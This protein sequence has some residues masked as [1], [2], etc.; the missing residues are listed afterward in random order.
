M[1]Q[2]PTPTACRNC[3]EPRSE[4]ALDQ[5][6]WCGACRAVVVRRATLIGRLAGIVTATLF[7]IWVFDSIAPGPRTMIFWLVLI[8]AVYFLL[9]KV[10][11]RVSFEMIRSRGVPP[12]DR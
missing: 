8:G 2:D 10:V 9:Y 3:R 11:Q 12:P 4:E 7:G 6:G 1:T 5:F